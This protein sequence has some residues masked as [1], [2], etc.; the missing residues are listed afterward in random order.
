MSDKRRPFTEG[1]ENDTSIDIL[2]DRMGE[3]T[4]AI[5]QLVV[6]LAGASLGSIPH[7]VIEDATLYS[8]GVDA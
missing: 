6:V 2:N 7:H 8:N 5:Q 3:L 4:V 1:H